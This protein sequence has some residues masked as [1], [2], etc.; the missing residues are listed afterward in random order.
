MWYWLITV[1]PLSPP[2]PCATH[3]PAVAAVVDALAQ[4]PHAAQPGA[5]SA[6]A[7]QQQPPAQRL[8]PQSAAEAQGSPGGCSA[9]APVK[10]V[11]AEQL[12]RAAA[13]AQQKPPRHGPAAQAVSSA[14]DAPGGCGAGDASGTGESG[15][16]G[17]GEG[18]GEGGGGGEGAVKEGLAV[19]GPVALAAADPGGGAQPSAVALHAHPGTQ[20]MALVV[21]A[22]QAGPRG[23]AGHHAALGAPQPSGARTA[24]EAGET[25][26]NTAC[27][28]HAA[29]EAPW[30]ESSEG[31]HCRPSLHSVAARGAVGANTLDA[32][33]ARAP[34]HAAH[35][36]AAVMPSVAAAPK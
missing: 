29:R 28:A 31:A 32:F 14:Q 17:E 19:A 5:S 11:H 21:S 24:D 34:S 20:R 13:G 7:A 2:P 26:V 30:Q 35:A 23:G 27:G 9:H 4:Q 18:G 8:V 3:A 10:G 25:N 22:V 16:E 33:P 12:A 1:A 6:E 15:G 36:G